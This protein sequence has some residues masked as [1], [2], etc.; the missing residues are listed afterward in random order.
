[1]ST[2]LK[3]LKNSKGKKERKKSVETNP[4]MTLMLE[5]AHNFKII[6]LTVLQDV[7]GNLLI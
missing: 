1:M 2:I 7:K 5:L 4:E 6:I 3:F